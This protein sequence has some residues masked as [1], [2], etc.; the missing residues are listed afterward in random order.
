MKKR[1]CH[2]KKVLYCTIKVLNLTIKYFGGRSSKDL[3]VLNVPTVK[4]TYFI[5][6]SWRNWVQYIFQSK[7]NLQLKRLSRLS[8]IE[9]RHIA[10]SWNMDQSLHHHCSWQQALLQLKGGL[11]SVHHVTHSH[12]TLQSQSRARRHN[13][14]VSSLHNMSEMDGFIYSEA[15]LWSL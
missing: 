5:T 3:L 1:Q 13:N 4:I 9:L 8:C 14:H 11:V 10:E 2:G 15:C 6:L 12:M 7:F